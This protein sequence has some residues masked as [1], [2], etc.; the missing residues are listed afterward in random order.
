MRPILIVPVLLL[1]SVWTTAQSLQAAENTAENACVAATDALEIQMQREDIIQ[2]LAD[3]DMGSALSMTKRLV[4]DIATRDWPND[5]H[6]EAE[7]MEKAARTVLDGLLAHDMR[8][9]RTGLN[10]LGTCTVNLH[11]HFVDDIQ[12]DREGRP[13]PRYEPVQRN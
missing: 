3:N 12:A 5:T 9:I 10:T 8:T 7:R 13:L 2:A 1:A 6:P 4:P 11:E